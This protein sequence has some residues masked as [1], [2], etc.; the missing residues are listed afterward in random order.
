MESGGTFEGQHCLISWAP[1]QDA[2]AK[3]Q[4]GLETMTNSSLQ[5]N[6]EFR[7]ELPY[8]ICL[9]A[10]CSSEKILSFLNTAVSGEIVATNAKCVDKYPIPLDEVDIAAM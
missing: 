1:S 3:I 5:L 7:L 4:I 2:M 8:G 10:T 6:E 9:P